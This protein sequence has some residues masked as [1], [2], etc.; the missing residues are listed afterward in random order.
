MNFS[1]HFKSA[2]FLSAFYYFALKK[3]FI[4]KIKLVQMA[5]REKEKNPI[6]K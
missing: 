4:K 2:H 1:S 6:T 3:F 5:N